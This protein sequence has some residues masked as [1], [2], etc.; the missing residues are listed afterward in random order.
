[1]LDVLPS[2]NHTALGMMEALLHV[3]ADF[4]LRLEDIICIVCDNASANTAMVRMLNNKVEQDHEGRADQQGTVVHTIHVSYCIQHSIHRAIVVMM[5]AMQ[6]C[7]AP[8]RRN[9]VTIHQSPQLAHDLARRVEANDRIKVPAKPRAK[10][11]IHDVPTR[12][13]ST[14]DMLA[15][16][17]LLRPEVEDLSQAHPARLPK[18]LPVHWALISMYCTLYKSAR[19][20]LTFPPQSCI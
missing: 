10:C 17:I 1:V 9:V 12:W 6:H 7:L 8:V 13:N 20:L 4:K 19:Y 11:V 5:A 16:L 18:L 3:L 14:S 2:E 15:R